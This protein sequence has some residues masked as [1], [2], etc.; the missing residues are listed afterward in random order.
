MTAWENADVHDATQCRRGRQCGAAEH[1]DVEVLTPGRDGQ[2]TPAT[3]RRLVPGRATA[4]GGLC[5]V[6]VSGAHVAVRQLPAD[7]AELQLLL[8]K[9]SGGGGVPVSGSRELQVPIRLGVD[10]LA[11]AIL[12][13]LERWAPVLA[14]RS[15]FAWWPAGSRAARVDH[16]AGWLMV[17]FDVLLDLPPMVVTRIDGGEERISGRNPMRVVEEDGVDAAIALL[18]LHDRV[19]AVAGRT[20]RSVR[21]QMPCPE[22]GRR[23][24]E[25]PE[26]PA[27]LRD[28]VHCIRCHHT[29]SW[30]SYERQALRLSFGPAG[31]R[32]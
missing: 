11:H 9:G 20:E 3:I 10:A 8:A 26:G 25:R 24:L 27:G 28:Y 18:Q 19:T 2:A 30:D 4:P 1:R 12:D 13:E 16:A 6:C 17:R 5:R 23:T 14:E 7:Y 29:M 22:C 21:L 31:G 15:G 32:G